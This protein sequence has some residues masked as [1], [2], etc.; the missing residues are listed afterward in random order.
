MFGDRP[1]V[2]PQEWKEYVRPHLNDHGLTDHQLDRLE[3]FFQQSFQENPSIPDWK[4]GIDQAALDQTMKYLRAHKEES[5]FDDQQ[6]D[7]IQ[8]ELLKYISIAT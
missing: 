7:L 1:R 2:T 3:G 8:A 4:P 5:L 6:L